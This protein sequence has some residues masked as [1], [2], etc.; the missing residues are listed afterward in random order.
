MCLKAWIYETQYRHMCLKTWLYDTHY[1]H[2]CLKTWLYDTHYRHM[3]L[4]TW[5]YDTHYRHMCL[6][7]QLIIVL[8]CTWIMSLLIPRRLLPSNIKLLRFGILPSSYGSL[9]KHIRNNL[10]YT[11]TIG[12][13]RKQNEPGGLTCIKDTIIICHNVGHPIRIIVLTVTG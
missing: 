9:Q 2:M 7:P 6:K 11:I 5:L 4:K 3:C 13:S 10:L 1:R 12:S 8:Q